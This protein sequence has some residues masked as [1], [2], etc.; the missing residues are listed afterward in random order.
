MTALRPREKALA[1]AMAALAAVLGVYG[2]FILPAI[3]R[4][5]TLER[6][7]PRRQREL[8]DLAA[9]TRQ[10]M[11][12]TSQVAAARQSLLTEPG[13]ELL[14]SIESIVNRQGL[15]THLT[16]LTPQ[17][18]SPEAHLAQTVVEMTLLRLTLR[19]V[20]DLL[21]EVQTTLPSIRINALHLSQ[22][23]DGPGWL[24]VTA[25][26]SMSESTASR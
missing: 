6:D 14:P 11:L 4:V 1:Y 24:N 26:L 21:G 23:P 16:S 22:H 25:M 7:L 15:Q 8:R 10:V 18:S 20:L 2:W 3:E 17:K 12:L 13:V 9:K 19:Q 5:H